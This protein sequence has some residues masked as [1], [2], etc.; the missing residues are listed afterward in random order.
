M[1]RPAAALLALVASLLA[2]SAAGCSD[3]G[4]VR[5]GSGALD[6]ATTSLP[7]G[8]RGQ[9]YAATLAARGGR[10]PYSWRLVTGA[11]PAGLTLDMTTGGISGV[12]VAAGDVGV[13]VARVIDVDS[14]FVDRALVLSVRKELTVTTPSPLPAAQLGVPYTVTLAATGGTLPYTW[15][16]VG[17]TSL[18]PGFS[19]NRLVGQ[20]VGIP[21]ARGTFTVSLVVTDTT[22]EAG[23]ASETK[24]FQ[25]T[26]S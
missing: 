24:T 15:D 4:S 26:V 14:F 13:F 25:L 9:A 22:N 20:L 3:D 18:P 17:G 2:W 1:T 19:L 7:Q 11:L 21:T 16:V 23:Q 10:P 6:I 5:F 12:P 8:T